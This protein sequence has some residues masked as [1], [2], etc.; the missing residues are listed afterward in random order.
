MLDFIPSVLEAGRGAMRTWLT[1]YFLRVRIRD[2]IL[3]G[4]YIVS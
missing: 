4:D 3:Y 2:E 1:H